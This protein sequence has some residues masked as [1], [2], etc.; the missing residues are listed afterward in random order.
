[1]MLSLRDWDRPDF[2]DGGWHGLSA[3]LEYEARL[4][5][6]R[7]I[8]SGFSDEVCTDP[9]RDENLRQGE[10]I[11][12][13]Y[14]AK[15]LHLPGDTQ[16][17]MLRPDP[18][19]DIEYGDVASSEKL[20]IT[21]AFVTW[22]GLSKRPGAAGQDH[23]VGMEKLTKDGQLSGYGPFKRVDGRIVHDEGARGWDEISEALLTG[24]KQALLGK[25]HHRLGDVTL[26]V[27]ATGYCEKM[28]IDRF[29][30]MAQDAIRSVGSL[31]FR[32]VVVLDYLPGYFRR[33]S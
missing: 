8:D 26:L 7:R 4:S 13:L 28:S 25:A 27:H 30:S 18:G 9:S 11:P 14:F 15:H 10:L 12:F 19:W 21:R 32:S 3:L 31:E 22:A 20:Q 23:R 29:L 1:M 6:A 33:F 24:L 16:F 17:R 5:A 2:G